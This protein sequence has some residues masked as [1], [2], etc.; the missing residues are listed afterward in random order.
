MELLKYMLQGIFNVFV[1]WLCLFLIIFPTCV[2]FSYNYFISGIVYI[3]VVFGIFVGILNY[4][5]ETDRI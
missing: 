2:L 3:V 4:L 1:A 5:I